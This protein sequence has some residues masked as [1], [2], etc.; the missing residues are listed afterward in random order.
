M[1]FELIFNSCN[2]PPPTDWADDEIKATVRA[3]FNEAYPLEAFS[4]YSLAK[5]PIGNTS[6]KVPMGGS[7]EQTFFSNNYSYDI[8]PGSYSPTYMDFLSASISNILGV[9][10][11]SVNRT[12]FIPTVS[13]LD[14]NVGVSEP[15]NLNSSQCYTNFDYIYANNSAS[16]VANN[17]HFSL[18]P[19]AEQFIMSHVLANETPRQKYFFTDVNLNIPAN[20]VVNNNEQYNKTAKYTITNNGYFTVNSGGSSTLLSSQSI[21]LKPGFSVSAGGVFSA[22]IRPLELM[23]ENNVE[24]VPRQLAPGLQ[25]DFTNTSIQ[26]IYNCSN[27][28]EMPE[29]NPNVIY[30]ESCIDSIS[31]NN[32]SSVDS[33]MNDNITVYPNPTSGI[34]NIVI[35]E[36]IPIDNLIIRVYDS[37]SNLIYTVNPVGSRNM[38]FNLPNCIPGLLTVQ[39]EFNNA[40]Y[41]YNKKVIKN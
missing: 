41:I 18:Q 30:S 1:I 33:I 22:S 39:F 31:Q 13:A 8:A 24:F 37:M 27:Y 38:Q 10:V 34:M 12:C 20:K 16:G 2:C 21:T 28:N 40:I 15:F 4:I 6:M 23:C 19:G 3:G 7:G 14:L 26:K 9:N 25:P 11:A 29:Y 32:I 35:T 5:Y 36:L 17:N